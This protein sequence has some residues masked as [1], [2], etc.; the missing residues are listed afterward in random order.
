MGAP[1]ITAFQPTRKF[2]GSGE[3]FVD[4][5]HV[6]EINNVTFT[7]TEEPV[8]QETG[9]PLMRS[10]KAILR[11]QA[12]LMAQYAEFS[13]R[14]LR[15][16]LNAT[17]AATGAVMYEVEGKSVALAGVVPAALGKTNI[18]KADGTAATEADITVMSA[19]GVV[20]PA[21]EYVLDEVAGTVA[22]TAL[23]SIPDGA[24]AVVQFAWR[25]TSAEVTHFGGL[26]S[27]SSL[28]FAPLR[29]IYK[30]SEPPCDQMEIVFH[31][32]SPAGGLTV[33]FDKQ[34]YTTRDI[35]FEALADLT[36]PQ[37]YRLGYVAMDPVS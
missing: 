18:C 6:G 24:T 22:R 16:A 2:F 31:R 12:S 11:Q 26:G 8:F 23:S 28:I 1:L 20:Y 10:A 33:N 27:C 5:T 29:F 37:G 21:N 30:F 17:T 3:L 36:R 35:T 34:A 32:A 9:R 13:T 7:V 19:D 15:Q 14:A 25:N 4:D